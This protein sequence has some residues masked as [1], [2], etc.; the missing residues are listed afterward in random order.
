MD[1]GRFYSEQLIDEA[2]AEGTYH[3]NWISVVYDKFPLAYVR[4]EDNELD[5][6]IDDNPIESYHSFLVK[7][8]RN[9]E[10]LSDSLLG[11]DSYEIID[12]A[13]EVNPGVLHKFAGDDFKRNIDREVMDRF[14]ERDK[15]GETEEI[16]DEFDLLF[17]GMDVIVKDVVEGRLREF[18][19]TMN[20]KP[21]LQN[22]IVV[23]EES[24]EQ[25]YKTVNA[26]LESCQ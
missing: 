24:L 8:D 4:M 2:K 11:L 14:E 22:S 9:R 13:F 7:L 20:R 25:L 15:D 3:D 19:E 6:L 17:E 12:N 16:G 21:I 23:Y 26:Q 10:Q 1:S 5:L 18:K